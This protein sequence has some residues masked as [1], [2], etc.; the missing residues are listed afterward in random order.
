VFYV[1]GRKHKLQV[2][3]DRLSSLEKNYGVK[4]VML[5]WDSWST[6]FSRPVENAEIASGALSEAFRGVRD[7]KEAHQEFFESHKISLICHSMG[8]LILKYFV[9][10]YLDEY[11]ANSD[12]PLF[13]NFVGT[14]ADVPLVGH[15]DW[16][17]KFN[18]AHNKYITMNNRDNVLLASHLLDVKNRE[19]GF[20]KLGLGFDN[21][22]GRKDHIIEKL[23]QDVSYIDLSDI[24]KGQHGYFLDSSPILVNIFSKLSNGEKFGITLVEQALL[25]VKI[26]VE[27]NISYIKKN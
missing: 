25:K 11:F 17:S 5:H 9:E 15:R 22:T 26:N 18:L 27:N 7:F 16:L 14:A 2:E 1:H 23:V 6:H 24:L 10:K 20:Y 13:E 8:N 4:V 19:L 21:S 12:S 3:L